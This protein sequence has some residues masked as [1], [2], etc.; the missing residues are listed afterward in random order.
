MS[1]SLSAI[2]N[3]IH[4][5]VYICKVKLYYL[6]I[7]LARRVPEMPRYGRARQQKTTVLGLVL[8]FAVSA[9]VG[10]AGMGMSLVYSTRDF[11]D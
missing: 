1:T 7:S 2:K 5:F 9:I 3:K 11:H 6:I 10:Y 8:A 4:L